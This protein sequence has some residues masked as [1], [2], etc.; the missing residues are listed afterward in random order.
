LYLAVQFP[1][2]SVILIPFAT[3]IHTNIPIAQGDT[4]VSIVQF[5][6]GGL[7]RFIDC[8]FLTEKEL[9]E[10]DPDLYRPPANPTEAVVAPA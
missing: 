2:G 8:S 5:V 4:G 10:K 6:A 1:S 7:F 3:V 9:K